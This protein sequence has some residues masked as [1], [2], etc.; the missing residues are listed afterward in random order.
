MSGYM[1]DRSTAELASLIEGAKQRDQA[2][3]IHYRPTIMAAVPCG[4]EPTVGASITTTA[5]IELVTCSRCLTL[6]AAGALTERPEV[7]PEPPKDDA[8]AA[9][10]L[11]ELGQVPLFPVGALPPRSTKRGQSLLDL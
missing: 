8:Q 4:A 5:S 7:P 10:K 3:A 6:T 2:E 1:G 9:P 11:A